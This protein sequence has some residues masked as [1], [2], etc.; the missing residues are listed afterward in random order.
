MKRYIT[1]IDIILADRRQPWSL[2][3]RPGTC[4]YYDGQGFQP[5]LFVRYNSIHDYKIACDGGPGSKA[6]GIISSHEGI[7]C[8]DDSP[9]VAQ[10]AEVFGLHHTFPHVDSERARCAYCGNEIHNYAYAPQFVFGNFHHE[11][12]RMLSHL[13]CIVGGVLRHLSRLP[14]LSVH[15]LRGSFK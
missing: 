12:Q 1:E 7:E 8:D 2:Y 6:S 11:G 14:G 15:P 10:F 4:F 3:V 9:A 13:E 5:S